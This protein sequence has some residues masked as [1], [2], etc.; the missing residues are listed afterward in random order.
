MTATPF[1]ANAEVELRLAEIWNTRGKRERALAGFERVLQA[2]PSHG[3]AHARRV[4]ILTD[5]QRFD[6]VIVAAREALVRC[7]DEATVH[8][9]YIGALR[10][11]GP[12]PAAAF[13][14][15]DLQP[16]DLQPVVIPPG[17]LLC[18]AT[19]RNEVVRLPYWLHYYRRHGVVR[20]LIVDNGSSDGTLDLLLQQPDVHVWRSGHSFK[21]ANFGSAWFEVLL[22]IYGLDHWV[23]TVD[24]DELLYFANCE[25]RTITNLCQDLD[26]SGKRALFALLLDM[27]SDRP[28]GETVLRPGQPFEEVC[29]FFD[30]VFAHQRY[31]R[32]GPYSNLAMVFGGVRQRV[33][34]PIGDYLLSKIPL[35]KYSADTVLAGGQHWTS[36]PE[37][38]IADETG[39]VLHFKFTS[40][41]PA[42]VTSEATR[43]EHAVNGFQYQEYARGLERTPDL[44]FYDPN[45]SVR[46]SD[47]AALV[48][49]GV[50]TPGAVATAVDEP[51]PRVDPILDGGDRPFWSVMLTVYDRVH[52]L[53]RA[54]RSVLDQN[55]DAASMQIEVVHDGGLDDSIRNQ[56]RAV[57]A[58]VGGPRVS[59]HGASRRLGHPHI[60]NYCIARARGQWVH[61]LHDDDWIEP[62]Y[63]AAMR[64]GIESSSDVG[65]AFSRWRFV[66]DRGSAVVQQ[67]EQQTAGVIDDWL[68]RI[69]IS[70]RIQMAAA[71]VRRSA[72]EQQG[73]F[74]PAA[75][76]AFDWELWK[77]L[78]VHYKAWYEPTPL[79]SFRQHSGA[80]S[81]HLL[82]S[83][84]QIADSRRTIE[85]SR[86]YLPAE[87]VEALSAAALDY[88]AR[89]ALTLA[90]RQL[91]SGDTQAAFAN[92]RE[93]LA[94]SRREPLVRAL[95]TMLSGHR[96]VVDGP[97]KQ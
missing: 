3:K 91:A 7:P 41:F 20:F 6:D 5:L 44:C 13:T 42:Y 94:C 27:Y 2:A 93:A 33:F 83:G 46:F 85:L 15:Y 89:W 35:L 38:A 80:E 54:L 92:I 28:V 56:L 60:F 21:A 61:L 53:E 29:P 68:E 37:S 26:R 81:H 50:M 43:R 90:G 52:Y 11:I 4:E 65:L 25:R 36:Y 77:R 73:G 31:E 88:Y 64:S 74:W 30:R 55:I 57:A 40:Q 51:I 63:Y 14:A 70:C 10:A 84:G 18:C 8:K 67:L 62:G 82:R 97:P 69:A 24:A 12:W 59:F 32:G 45:Y 17:A 19:V 87:R 75:G 48:A 9:N 76:S 1:Y 78:A 16:T 66:N 58:A 23:V 71:V 22:Q 49:L 96:A 47:T 95:V 72:Y 34:G 79:A 39:A 86:R